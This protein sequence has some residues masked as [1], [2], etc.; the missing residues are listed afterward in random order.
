MVI[1]IRHYGM[2]KGQWQRRAH[3]MAMH[4][5]TVHM[6][7]GETPASYYKMITLNTE[8]MRKEIT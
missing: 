7:L 2:L 4:R 3:D 1:Y 5:K 6:V 8:H